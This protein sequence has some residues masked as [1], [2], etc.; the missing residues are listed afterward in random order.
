MLEILLKHMSSAIKYF[1]IIYLF[2]SSSILH[3]N[4]KE[5]ILKEFIKKNGFV[6]HKELFNEKDS[7]LSEVGKK[8]FDSKS[9]SLNGDI[10]CS[11]CHLDNKGSADGLPI[12]AAIGGSGEGIE[13]FKS[14]AQL[15]PRNTLPFWGRGGIGFDTFFWDGKVQLKEGKVLSQFGSSPPSNDPFEVAVHLPA[16]QIREMLSD[17]MGV[18]KL[19]QENVDLANVTYDIIAEKLKEYEKIASAKLAEV[20]RKRK[21]DLTFNDYSRSLAAFIRDKFRIR[22]TKLEKFVNDKAN[23]SENELNGGL[24]FYGKGRC[25]TCHSGP[26]FSD[27]NFYSIPFPQL[28]FGANGFGVDYGRYNI[29]FD[30]ND[31]YKFRT[32]PLHNVEKTSPYG[33]DGS[34]STLNE[35]IIAHFDPLRLIDINKMD[36]KKRH[37]F[38]Q[39]LASSDSSVVNYLT[40]DEV[41][42]LV[43]FLKLLSY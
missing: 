42:D 31:L 26:Y 30:T 5:N 38:Y 20:L 34:L 28:G 25:V 41:E 21:N 18:D 2:L 14:G 15:L 43:Y 35:A 3:A 40:D 36:A 4:G 24:I 19:K 23:L 7:N 9:I 22:E 12:A 16:V 29:T 6:S 11:T 8:L 17:G 13:R 33:H 39:K 1:I 10:S 32:P 37:Y 27:F